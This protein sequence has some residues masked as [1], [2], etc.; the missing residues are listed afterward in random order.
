MQEKT[1]KTDSNNVPCLGE[2][3]R[4]ERE[5]RGLS[6]DQVAEITRL[7]KHFIEALENEDWEKLPSPV[8]VKGFI[9]S[10]AQVI[11]F[12]GK[13]AIEMFERI[14]PVEDQI[15]KPLVGPKE[16]KR[17]CIYFLIPL[18][19]VVAV[20][21]YIYSTYLP[22]DEAVPPGPSSQ[23]VEQGE[24]PEEATTV[25]G[26]IVPL[27]PPEEAETVTE[28][29]V[30]T[31]APEEAETGPE[32][33]GVPAEA[34]ERAGGTVEEVTPVEMAERVE[35][36]EAPDRGP[37]LIGNDLPPPPLEEEA[38]VSPPEGSPTD[39]DLV[40]TG[41]VN[42]RTYVK[43]YMDDNLP[44]EYIFEPGSR[45]QWRAKKGFNIILG[46]AAGMEFDLNGKRMKDFG[47]LG[48]VVR[49]N[50]PEDFESRFYEE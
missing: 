43:I 36:E 37:E 6:Q 50:F 49:L 2:F 22:E 9:R 10:Y 42:L 44:K 1:E 12:D 39:N 30:R 16:S 32:E 48:K 27:E 19:A 38:P 4:N 5:K 33:M 11:G 24:P 23:Q 20:V 18:I 45:P 41:I 14:A 26:E 28:E 40:L 21:L 35:R 25:P 3:L 31:G 8:F 13:E 34:P 47:K 7:R 17:K 46:N 29:A 15:P